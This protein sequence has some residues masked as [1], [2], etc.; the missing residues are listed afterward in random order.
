LDPFAGAGTTLLVA[1]RLNRHGIGIE[2]NPEYAAMA[3]RR[4]AGDN[5]MFSSVEDA[6]VFAPLPPTLPDKQGSLGKRTYTGFNARWNAKEEAARVSEP[7]PIPL[8]DEEVA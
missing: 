8:F 7:A 1:D 3:R 5:P 4:I 6:P 2:L